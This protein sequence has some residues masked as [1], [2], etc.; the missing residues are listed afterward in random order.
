MISAETACRVTTCYMVHKALVNQPQYLSDKLSFQDE[1]FQSRT[2]HGNLLNFP[3]VRLK[4]GRR[5]FS[6][7][8][9]KVYNDLKL[10]NIKVRSVRY[11]KTK[12]RQNLPSVWI[13]FF[14]FLA[15][16]P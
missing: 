6:Y 11:L 2:S 1:I 12:I 15:N 13:S 9:P 3:K 8:G 10:Q 14:L 5:S 4:L 7:L 16:F